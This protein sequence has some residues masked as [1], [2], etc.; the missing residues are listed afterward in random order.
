MTN[1][2]TVEAFDKATGMTVEELLEFAD[3]V[4][5]MTGLTP[6]GMIVHV[7]TVEEQDRL[8]REFESTSARPSVLL[9]P[10][11]TPRIVLTA[12]TSMRGRLRR[13]TAKV[14]RS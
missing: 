6:V 5:A 13:L 7:T 3:R 10:P 4:R 2:E 1:I 14:D 8:R 11:G 9:P 12:E